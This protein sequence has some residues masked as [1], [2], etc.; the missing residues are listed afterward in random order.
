MSGPSSSNIEV[1]HGSISAGYD[2]TKRVIIIIVIIIMCAN[3]YVKW[4]TELI[5]N[6]N[7]NGIN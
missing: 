6:N 5:I 1:S 3:G 4:K 2:N 7:N